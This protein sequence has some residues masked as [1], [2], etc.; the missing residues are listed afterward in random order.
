MPTNLTEMVNRIAG[1]ALYRR[2]PIS[3]VAH[4]GALY[5]EYGRG[6][7]RLALDEPARTAPTRAIGKVA[8]ADLLTDSSSATDELPD[9]PALVPAASAP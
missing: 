1:N 3:A 4:L 5:A 6:I 2:L 7:P 8:V 9:H